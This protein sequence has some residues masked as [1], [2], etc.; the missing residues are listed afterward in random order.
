MNRLAKKK[1]LVLVE[2]EKTD[3]FVMETLLKTYPE[4]DA[5]YQIVPYCTNI[6]TLYHAFFSGADTD[7]TLDLLQVLKEKERDPNRKKQLDNKYTDILLIFDLDPQ[8]NLFTGEKIRQMQAYFC[9]SSDMGKLYLNYPMI[10]SFFHMKSLPDNEYHNRTVH[11]DVLKSHR[12]KERVH[13]ESYKKDHRKFITSRAELNY[14]IRENAKKASKLTN[15]TDSADD[16]TEIDLEAVL[17]KQLTFLQYDY[18]QVL[19][20]CIL[21][22]F[23]YNRNLLFAD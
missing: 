22:I 8:D 19:C 5:K 4:L 7:D 1:I 12:Y 20:T 13:H 21:Y 23:D 10:E 18:L 16:Y 2:G 17:E 3:V 15:T 9:E 11:M 14:V 6:Y